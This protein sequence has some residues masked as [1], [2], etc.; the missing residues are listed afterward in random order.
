M[1]QWQCCVTPCGE[2]Y[3]DTECY[4]TAEQVAG[5]LESVPDHELAKYATY[6]ATSTL[7]DDYSCAMFL[8]PG[9]CCSALAR[10]VM[11]GWD[12]VTE[13]EVVCI[14]HCMDC[15]GQWENDSGRG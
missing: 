10:K 8:H 7:S 14:S 5:D 1:T 3:W 15:S 9:N 4:I 6:I 13:M 2:C 12:D 11:E